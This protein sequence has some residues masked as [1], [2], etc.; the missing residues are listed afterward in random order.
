MQDATCNRRRLLCGKGS[1][2]ISSADSLTWLTRVTSTANGVVIAHLCLCIV[3]LSFCDWLCGLPT[4][5]LFDDDLG[6]VGDSGVV[7]SGLLFN[8]PPARDFDARISGK[9]A[10]STAERC[11]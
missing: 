2:C 11:R 8:T 1:A 4:L 9:C 3:G 5:V 10:A 6:P 7:K